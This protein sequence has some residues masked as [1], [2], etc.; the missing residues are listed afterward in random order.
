[1][2]VG[3]GFSAL[4]CLYILLWPENIDY[5]KQWD[6]L[7]STITA[8]SA[9][10][11]SEFY[12]NESPHSVQPSQNDTRVA[13]E[14]ITLHAYKLRNLLKEEDL[15]SLIPS[16]Y[17]SEIGHL[18]DQWDRGLLRFHDKELNN[19]LKI[20]IERL[21]KLS[22]KIA[23]DTT[24]ELIGGKLKTGYKPIKYVKDEEYERLRSESK[25]AN[26]LA[27]QAWETLVELVNQI[28]KKIPIALD[29]PI[30]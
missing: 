30:N 24:P 17:Y 3:L 22:N 8:I 29:D 14:L 18:R 15:W 19:S 5:I 11:F 9:W 4:G 21:E 12:F 16:E 20:F 27:S 28:H 7:I 10:V 13:R 23:H 1:M 25:E 2:R 6:K 26:K